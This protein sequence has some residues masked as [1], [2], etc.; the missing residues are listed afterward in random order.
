[1]EALEAIGLTAE[2]LLGAQAARVLN[3]LMRKKFVVNMLIST[4][5][6]KNTV[7]MLKKTR[8]VKRVNMLTC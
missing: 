2:K 3:M 4:P 8:N 5:N 1:M 7:L 6:V